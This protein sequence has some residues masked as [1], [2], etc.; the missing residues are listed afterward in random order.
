MLIQSF[1]EE[2]FTFKDIVYKE[3]SISDKIFIVTHFLVAL[4]S[5]YKVTNLHCKLCNTV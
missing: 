1:A 3:G 2:K 5:S 4:E